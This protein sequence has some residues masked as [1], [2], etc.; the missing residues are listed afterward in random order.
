VDSAEE[1]ARAFSEVAGAGGRVVL[2]P[3]RGGGSRG[4]VTDIDSPE[5]AAQAWTKVD[6][7]LR[8]YMRRPD[9]GFG[10]LDQYPGILM[11]GQLIGP[12][13]DAEFVTRRGPDG[14]PVVD[15]FMPAD[16]APV[17]KPWAV[18]KGDTF[19]SQLPTD[20]W[21]QIREAGVLALEALGLTSGNAHIEMIVTPDGPKIL[22]VN[23]RMGGLFVKPMVEKVT[24]FDL[25]EGAIR[26]YLGL[27]PKTQEGPWITLEARS[28]ASFHSGV[29]E[30]IE[31]LEQVQSMP[32]FDR[33]MLIKKKGDR[34]YS[35]EED[36]DDYPLYISATGP[37]YRMTFERVIEMMKVL[38]LHIRKDDG[39]LVV[40]SLNE[41]HVPYDPNALLAQETA[42]AYRR[43][44]ER[45]EAREREQ[46]RALSGVHTLLAG[47]SHDVR[48]G[49][50]S[51]GMAVSML[52]RTEGPEEDPSR[53]RYFK[54]IER[55]AMSIEGAAL[56]FMALARLEEGS[57]SVIRR[58][59]EMSE[60]LRLIAGGQAAHADRKNIDISFDF[61]EGQ[62][63]AL[64]DTGAVE[65]A[66]TN[67]LG[68]AIKY[69][70][71]DGRVRLGLS[72]DAQGWTTVTVQDSGV[73]IGAE[74][75]SKILAGTRHR[76]DEGK[77]M[78]SGFGI[79]LPLVKQILE[80][81]GTSLQ[82]RSEPG[83]GSEFSFRLPPASPPASK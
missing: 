33:L 30:D 31:G 4:V 60:L 55:A 42:S 29:I 39:T 23:K 20:V 3:I 7:F 67:L 56:N 74:D 19:P 77:K 61:P 26:A 40:Q 12:E 36:M 71:N 48:N 27:R 35:R 64:A 16:N 25:V 70:P 59:V 68:N 1:A 10:N 11:E 54:M 38:K 83:R 37:D 5:K 79:G 53:G 81:L 24:G 72:V 8:E 62:V 45:S 73:G 21:A 76:T 41:G 57:W 49:I 78:A 9:A 58:P 50:N 28:P 69:T 66:A 14:R 6:A 63:W 47:M 15:F 17:D 13:I 46:Q 34:I 65:I 51:I 44:K 2:K 22:E 75:L 82:V 18:E 52:K 80:S 43:L 32:G